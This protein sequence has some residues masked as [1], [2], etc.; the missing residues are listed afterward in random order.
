MEQGKI[1]LADAA[2]NLI[3]R[4]DAGVLSTHSVE[5]EGY[6]FGSLTP[7]VASP[8]GRPVILVNSLAQHSRNISAN[9][10]VCLTVYDPAEKDKLASNRVSIMGSGTP[11]PADERAALEERY[12]AFFPHSRVWRDNQG[13]QFFWIE[14]HRVRFVSGFGRIHWLSKEGWLLPS[15]LWRAEEAK[16]IA[17]I[18]E[19]QGAALIDICKY[20]HQRNVRCASV[21]ALDPEGFHLRADDDILYFVLERTCFAREEIESEIS[22]MAIQARR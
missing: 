5:V 14:P 21:I 12:F 22:R 2:R 10:R 6:P 19:G 11:V 8:E 3:R 13:F 18:N 9:P 17:R 16:I 7:F 1:S 15:P 4:M 20:F